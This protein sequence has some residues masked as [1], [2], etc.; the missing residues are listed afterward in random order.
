MTPRRPRRPKKKARKTSLF[1]TFTGSVFSTRSRT[2]GDGA[3]SSR[4]SRAYLETLVLLAALAGIGGL[5]VY[6]VWPP[7]QEYLYKHAEALMASTHRSD[8]IKARDEYFDQLDRRFPDNPY[9]EQGARWRDKILLDEAESRSV[10]LGADRVTVINQPN[11][12]AERLFVLIN[13][14]AT[15]ASKRGDDL[16]ALQQWKDMAAK[17]KPDDKDDR[18]WYLLALHRAEQLENAIRDRRQFVETQLRLADEADRTGRPN[19]AITIR[20]K[21]VDQYAGYTDLADL[22][23][24]T[25]AQPGTAP[26]PAGRRRRRPRRRHRVRGRASPAQRRRDRRRGQP[27]HPPRPASPH[28]PAPRASHP[29]TRPRRPR[30]PVPRPPIPSVNRS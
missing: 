22:F 29:R 24:G 28:R 18:P 12:N 21:L 7:G 9:R 26:A 1:S 13:G 15:E 27:V 30:N 4:P 8:W 6:L 17:L 14:V 11:T 23:P 5:I 2:M 3:D 16:A 25:A 10:Y 20:S 19:Q